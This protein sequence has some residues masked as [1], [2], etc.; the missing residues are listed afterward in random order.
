ML[1]LI[2]K[3]NRAVSMTLENKL[4]NS[5]LNIALDIILKRVKKSPERCARNIIEL[6]FSS[7]PNSINTINKDELYN[8]ILSFCK[9][10]DTDAIKKLFFQSFNSFA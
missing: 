3:R 1:D 8:K 4:K 9:S 10:L 6:G 5:G 2:N 7:F